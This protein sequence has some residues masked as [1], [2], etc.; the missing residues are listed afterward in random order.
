MEGNL[1]FPLLVAVGVLEACGLTLALVMH[2]QTFGSQ[3][4]EQ[5]LARINQGC[6][7]V[8]PLVF[9]LAMLVAIVRARFWRK[10]TRITKAVF[11][12]LIA[13]SFFYLLFTNVSN[14]IYLSERKMSGGVLSEDWEKNDGSHV[15]QSHG[16]ILRRLTAEEYLAFAARDY[17][18]L[19]AALILAYTIFGSSWI[20]ACWGAPP[21]SKLQG[22]S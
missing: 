12:G 6:W 15:L 10:Q 22:A 14:S 19:T 5:V 8:V 18:S 7:I 9:V 21:D 11:I 1:R 16:K 3:I 2:I 20:V 17:R 4:N 13:I